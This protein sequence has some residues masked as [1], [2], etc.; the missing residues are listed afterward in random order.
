M[1][2]CQEKEVSCDDTSEELS[3]L[4]SADITCK[5]CKDDMTPVNL[6]LK[7]SSLTSHNSLSLKKYHANEPECSRLVACD[8]KML[9]NKKPRARLLFEAQLQRRAGQI[10]WMFVRTTHTN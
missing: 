1:Y 7:V 10:L 8:C 5:F 6:A 3:Q 9:T 2:F 4:N